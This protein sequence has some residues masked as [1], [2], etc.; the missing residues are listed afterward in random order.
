MRI[1]ANTKISALI[2]ENPA[3]IE[4]IASINRHF[5]KLR[6][7]LLRKV[8]ASRVTIADAARIGGCDVERFYE[9]LRPL[10]FTVSDETTTKG[11]TQSQ[12][13]P[14]TTGMPAFLVELPAERLLQL[15][16]REDIATG[17]DPFLKIMDAVDGIDATNALLIINTFEPTPLIAILKKKGYGYFTD[18]KSPDLVYTYFWL[19]KAPEATAVESIAPAGNDFEKT[20]ARFAGKVKRVDVRH[21][22]MPQPMITILGELENLPTEE[23]LY[24]VHKRVPQFLLPQLEERGF[25]VAI[26]EVGPNE[27][28]L[29][30]YR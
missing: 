7:P 27:V 2:K 28:Y 10:G 17:S 14:A 16:V 3:A 20:L 22:E 5:E 21:L 1:A 19:E 26:N 11:M 15:D 12:S 30:I 23:A 25:K 6:N 9:K 4:A 8:L 29:L 24:V 13:I 18:T